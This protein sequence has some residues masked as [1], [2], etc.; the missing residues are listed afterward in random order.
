MQLRIHLEDDERTMVRELLDKGCQVIVCEMKLICSL[1]LGE[2][3]NEC[4]KSAVS[5]LEGECDD[6]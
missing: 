3:C 5:E 4:G 6:S 2:C 1:K